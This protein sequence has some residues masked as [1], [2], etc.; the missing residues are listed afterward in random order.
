MFSAG[1]PKTW[2][3]KDKKQIKHTFPCP[4]CFKSQSFS[5]AKE[6][7]KIF[8]YLFFLIIFFPLILDNWLNSL[9]AQSTDNP[10]VK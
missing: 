5:V 9:T 10:M 3:K 2:K 1:V 6:E 4:E 7:K 8:Q